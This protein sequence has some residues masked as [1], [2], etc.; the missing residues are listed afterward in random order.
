[1]R[2]N[3]INHITRCCHFRIWLTYFSFLIVSF[4]KAQDPHFSQFYAAPL[5]LNPA[6]TGAYPGNLRISSC[7]REQWNSMMVPYKTGTFSIDANLFNEKIQE[8]NIIGVGLTGLFD[9]SNNGG[10]LSN[11]LSGSLAFHKTLYNVDGI[12]HSLGGGFM[13][14]MN[15]KILDYS[16]FTFPQQFSSLG[17]NP[18]LPTGEN[19]NGFSSINFDISAGL[20]YSI[21]SENNSIYMGGSIYHI[22]STKEASNSPFA[23]IAPRY[24]MHVGGS[25]L[26]NEV[27]RIYMSGVFM[28]AKSYQEL[29]LGVVYGYSLTSTYNYDQERNYV[30][31]MGGLWYRYK[32]AIIPYM[33]VELGNARVGLSYDINLSQLS[34]V[35]RFRGG[36]ELSISY[37]FATTAA[38]KLRKETLCPE[39]KQSALKWYGY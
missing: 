31:L 26:I 2:S 15:T 18:N 24:V 29:I 3:S 25:L 28:N 1:M 6:L 38:A 35:S 37:T 32:D 33:G 17:F 23:N 8:G 36:F 10:L 22:N 4:S 13:T 19:K 9:N 20:L 11:T 14:S 16:R 27:D 5:L 12:R 21:I 34:P 39:G 7:F 30:N